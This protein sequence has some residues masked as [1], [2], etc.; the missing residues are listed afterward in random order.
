MAVAALPQDKSKEDAF[1]LNLGPVL[2]SDMGIV[3]RLDPSIELDND[4]LFEFCQINRD[5]RI[6]RDEQGELTIMAPAGG[7]TAHRN[8][9]L[10]MQLQLWAK[11]NGTG[12][13][14]DSSSGFR[15]GGKAMLSPDA[16][17]IRNDRYDKLSPKEKQEFPPLCPDFVIELRSSS[18]RLGTVREKMEEWIEQGARLGWLIDP[19][20]KRVYVY[21]PNQEVEIVEDV[22]T[23]SGEP[24]LPGFILDLTQIW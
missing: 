13:A 21:R 10:T 8:A 17:W 12:V 24:V 22:P 11:Q 9:E 18:D 20:A 1:V 19:K 3:F 23:L 5:L 14:F 2:G 6:E 7:D 4:E 16:A 15:L